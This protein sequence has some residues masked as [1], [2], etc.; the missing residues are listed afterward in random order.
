MKKYIESDI[1]LYDWQ[2]DCLIKWHVNNYRGIINV[3]TG[4]GKTILAVAAIK[5]L[6]EK[7]CKT[8]RDSSLKVKIIVPKI[9]LAGQWVN[10]LIN[11]LGAKRGEIGLYYGQSK[12]DENRKYMIYVL[13]SARYSVSSHILNDY[14]N[15]CHVLLICDECHHFGSA[16]NSKVFDFMS[17]IDMSKYFSLGLSATPDLNNPVLT[18]S[19][20]GEIYKYGFDMAVKTGVV[21]E[22]NVFNISLD[23]LDDE[24]EEYYFLTDKLT[25]LYTKIMKLLPYLKNL[26][27]QKNDKF[28]NELKKIASAGNGQV[29]DFASSILVTLYKRKEIVYLAQNRILC[30]EELLKRLPGNRI[31]VFCERISAVDELY[32]RLKNNRVSISVGKY[33]S[34]MGGEARKL[35][36]ERYKNGEINILLSCRALDEGLNVPETDTGII[37]SSTGSVRQRIQRVGRVLRKIGGNQIKSIY[38]MYIGD[39]FNSIEECEVIPN[40]KF[41]KNNKNSHTFNLSYNSV[42][43][44]FICDEY[45]LLC[46]SALKRLGENKTLSVIL[47]EVKNNFKFGIIKSDWKLSE[48]ECRAKIEES[49]NTSEKNYWISMLKIIVA[50]NQ[51]N[52]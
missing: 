29:S 3:A 22:Y 25:V 50:N 19:L 17:H 12:E 1:N 15:N 45:D 47:D 24:S 4:A 49:K 9:F 39:F 46:K 48:A 26:R 33:H 27:K 16:E 44:D 34:E 36:L 7:L 23:F 14:K 40:D 6:C 42:K 35:A 5:T 51:I 32:N 30:A 20:G 8:D 18:K 31:I 21:A 38:Y 37:M 43:N 2:K 10:T 52:Q 13:N 28:Y 41:D 11:V